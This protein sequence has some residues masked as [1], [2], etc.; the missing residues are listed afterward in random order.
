MQYNNGKDA[1]IA[2]KE[3]LAQEITELAFKSQ[4]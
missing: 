2:G 3:A 1:Y 4:I